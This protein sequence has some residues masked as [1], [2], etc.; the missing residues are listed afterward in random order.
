MNSITETDNIDS[1]EKKIIIIY[2]EFNGWEHE[3]WIQ[4]YLCDKQYLYS[5]EVLQFFFNCFNKQFP[6]QQ[7][8]RNQLLPFMCSSLVDS[9][10]SQYT[11]EIIKTLTQD[12]IDKIIKNVASYNRRNSYK[13]SNF[14]ELSIEPP[15]FKEIIHL[16]EMYNL[17]KN[18]FTFNKKKIMNIIKDEFDNIFDTV[19]KQFGNSAE[20]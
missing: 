1:I 17:D 12:Q 19:Y 13:H 10:A 3:T 7:V 18:N 2:K 11:I 5:A 4:A 14:K 20:K 6:E 15:H 16:I 9:L 8:K